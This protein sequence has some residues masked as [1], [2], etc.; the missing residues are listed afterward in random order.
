AMNWQQYFSFNDKRRR[1]RAGLFVLFLLIH[2]FL[3]QGTL[4]GELELLCPLINVTC[5]ENGTVPASITNQDESA[6]NETKMP[7]SAVI[8]EVNNSVVEV[9]ESVEA[10][11]DGRGIRERLSDAVIGS[12]EYVWKRAWLRCES[13]S[14]WEA[15]DYAKLWL[16]RLFYSPLIVIP[17]FLLAH[18]FS[19]LFFWHWKLKL[20]EASEGA[21]KKEK[22]GEGKK[23]K[24]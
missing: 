2:L 22:K 5:N 12:A 8:P 19:L 4:H 10:E 1:W 15:K 14:A 16:M 24:K 6:L 23:D 18:L 9:N 20:D 13:C 21:G 11:A 17:D 7:D 3:I